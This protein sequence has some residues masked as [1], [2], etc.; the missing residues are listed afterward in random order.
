M[1]RSKSGGTRSFIRGRVG[2]DVY[3]IGKDGSGKKQQV[4]RSLAEQVAN[5]RTVAQMRNRMIMA[6]VMQAQSALASI[7]D[8]SFDGVP[9]GQPSI[10]RFIRENFRIMS[11]LQDADMAFY[12]P[13]RRKGILFN[14]FILSEG[15]VV[16][17]EGVRMGKCTVSGNP[18]FNRWGSFVIMID[19]ASVTAKD[20]RDACIYTNDGDYFTG[21]YIN[22][23]V[24]QV[25]QDDNVTGFTYFDTPLVR[26]MRIKVTNTLADDTVLTSANIGQMFE[27]E[28]NEGKY[29]VG[30]V[31]N[32][33]DTDICIGQDIEGEY[34]NNSIVC[35]ALI[36]TKKTSDGY[37]HSTSYFDPRYDEPWNNYTDALDTYPIGETKFLNGGEI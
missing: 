31:N 21:I 23:G 19:K 17:P 29:A 22:C 7:I 11:L 35:D 27:V 4:I 1:A 10:S 15:N 24:Y 2:A 37:E 30:I 18:Y 8:H 6:T 36:V 25:D 33:N 26:I 12:N 32:T 9:A 13:Y 14:P 5:P 34:R 3:T 16:K 20:V 28:M